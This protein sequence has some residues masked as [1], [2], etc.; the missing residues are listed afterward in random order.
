MTELHIVTDR[1]DPPVA[2]LLMFEDG[3]FAAVGP[4]LKPDEFASKL[5]DAAF[6]T[7]SGVVD[8]AGDGL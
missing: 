6:A 8:P 3:S 5:V 7:S 2:V 1:K 4:N